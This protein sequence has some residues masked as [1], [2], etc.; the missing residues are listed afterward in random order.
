[1]YVFVA[2][3]IQRA[4]RMGHIVM[5]DLPR[6]TTFFYIILR[7]DFREKNIYWTQNVCFD[8]LYSFCI[9]HFSF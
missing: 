4:M 8:F 5:R 7:H 6:S 1:V 3:G 9:K 2:L